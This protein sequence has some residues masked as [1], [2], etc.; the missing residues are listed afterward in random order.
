V[1]RPEEM[2]EDLEE[3]LAAL[4]RVADR[5]YTRWIKALK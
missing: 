1:Q 3:R 2:R 4:R 5:V